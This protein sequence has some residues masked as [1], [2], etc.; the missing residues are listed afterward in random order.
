MVAF[1]VGSG[2]AYSPWALVALFAFTAFGIFAYVAIGTPQDRWWLKYA[3]YGADVLGVCALFAVMPVSR[4]Q[5]I[6]QIVAFRAFGIY[7]LF[8]LIAMACLSLSWRLVAFSGVMA[9]VGH[10]I[11]SIAHR[12]AP[13]STL[14]PFVYFQII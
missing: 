1:A 9:A 6:P 4:G 10:Q 13:A 14:A 2:P 11:F 12:M 8:P 7:Y 5:D 3:L